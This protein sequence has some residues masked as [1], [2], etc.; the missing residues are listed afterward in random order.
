MKKAVLL[1][2]VVLV[3]A[4]LLGRWMAADSGY[5]LVIRDNWEME[6]TLGFA[7]L[8]MIAAAVIL[9]VLTLLVNLVWN[10]A[11][12]VRATRRFRRRTAHR[13]LKAG[14]IQ[15]VDGELDKAERLLVAAGEKGDWPLLG[16]LMAAE[17]A[18]EKRDGDALE[19]YLER[20]AGER[21]G[22]LVS[23]L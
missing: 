13:R 21:R 8:A 7:V 16:W 6:T 20:A 2:I 17:V 18:H 19:H 14:F 12:P 22:E 3:A 5:V 15:L 23:G 1:I 4:T 9:V 11:E 10:L